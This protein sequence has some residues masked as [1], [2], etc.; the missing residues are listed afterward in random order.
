MR[1]QDF[2]G[3]AT[4]ILFIHGLGCAGPFDYPQAVTQEGLEGHRRILLSQSAAQG[5]SPPWREA[6][7]GLPVAKSFIFGGKPLPDKD[8][9]GLENHA[10]HVET[11]PDAGHSM[12]WE[13]PKGLAAAIIRCLQG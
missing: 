12:A 10:I 1:Y 8:Y 6:L 9:E 5:G 11:V 4:P 2:P 13:N 3:D 7:Y